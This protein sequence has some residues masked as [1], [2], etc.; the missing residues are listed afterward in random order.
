MTHDA[1]DAAS[2]SCDY[3]SHRVACRCGASSGGCKHVAQFRTRPIFSAGGKLAWPVSA[4][5]EDSNGT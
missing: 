4:D 3:I 5:V 1:F 2:L